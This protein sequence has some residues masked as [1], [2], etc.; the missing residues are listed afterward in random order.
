MV[1]SY[2]GVL[3]STFVIKF[4][5]PQKMIDLSM[6][7]QDDAILMSLRYVMNGIVRSGCIFNTFYFGFC[8]KIIVSVL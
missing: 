2:R 8:I 1:D 7:F 3:D 5:F 4:W 6:Y